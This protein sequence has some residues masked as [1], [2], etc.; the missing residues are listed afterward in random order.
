VPGRLFFIV[1]LL[2]LSSPFSV[3]A[4][5]PKQYPTNG[6][7]SSG[8]SATTSSAPAAGS[9]L[10]S[11]LSAFGGGGAGGSA[12]G[13]NNPN[14][15]SNVVS[16]SKLEE[17]G[18][19]PQSVETARTEAMTYRS[20][21]RLADRGDNQKI[22]IN[23]YSGGTP[24]MYIF[25]THGNCI[26]KTA[27]TYGNGAGHG[28]PQPC[29]SDSSHLTP[30]GFHLTAY[31]NG[32]KYGADDSLLMVGLEGQN[33]AS[34]SILIHPAAQPGTASSWG[35]SGVGYNCARTIQQL[36]GTGALVYNYF[37]SKPLAPGCGSSAGMSH[38][39]SCQLDRSAPSIPAAATGAS[40]AGDTVR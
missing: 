6:N 5:V 4:Q 18:H 23:D 9:L 26:A 34:R 15:S 11:F 24:T 29:A 36:L 32:A 14:T 16:T 37:G 7:T 8:N 2:G 35:C 21:C 3:F 40:A 13:S 12:G 28:A 17:C 33:S 27:V 19:T 22:V 10:Q 25:D 31:H 20:Q 1:C 38:S 39:T 30:P